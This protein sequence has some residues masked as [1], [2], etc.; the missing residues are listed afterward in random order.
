MRERNSNLLSLGDGLRPQSRLTFLLPGLLVL[1]ACNVDPDSTMLTSSETGFP[2][3]DTGTTATETADSGDGDGDTTTSSTTSTTSG[4]G[5]DDT[6]DSGNAFCGDSVI[7]G[8]EVCDCGA[9]GECTAEELDMMDCTTVTD[10]VSGNLFDGGVLTC[11]MSCQWDTSG[12][13]VC[14]DGFLTDTETCDGEQ[15]GT[16]TC[17]SE[18]FLGGD[19]IC[20]DTCELD[21][22]MCTE[23]TWFEGF[24]ETT[25]DLMTWGFTGESP[26]V[27][28][29]AEANGG[30]QSA[31]S[32]A[33]AD[34]GSSSIILDMTWAAD[35]T[36]A[37]NHKHD[38][39]GTLDKLQFFVDDLQQGV[40]WGG[41]TDWTDDAFPIAA[42]T[43]RLEWRYS[44]DS[45]FASG[46]D[47]AWIDNVRS[48]GT[49]AIATCGDDFLA[50]SEVCDGT[51]LGLNTCFNQGFLGGTLACDGS[52]Q[53]DTSGCTNPTWTEDW[54]TGAIDAMSWGSAGESGWIIDS[55]GGNAN[56]SFSAN[57]GAIGDSATSD[58][59]WTWCGRKTARWPSAT[60]PTA[61]PLVTS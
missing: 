16:N 2:T 22:S 10:P 23:A 49:V 20:T 45:S 53:L 56:S 43:H 48:D 40:D 51:H 25:I 54:E 17:G 8:F 36:I 31:R 15:F 44:K 47:A 60:R 57:S 39:E 38:S 41:Q 46:A 9:D 12:C 19:L 30:T 3:D 4:D 7:E 42:G 13:F 34:N 33:T 32:G 5:D 52:C 50:T 1:G 28:D 61:T 27:I 21:T 59:S 35:G 14:G 58:S 24:E 55:T 6:T 29:T 18:G 37:F 11:N 26:W